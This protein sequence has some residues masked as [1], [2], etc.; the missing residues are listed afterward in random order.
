LDEASVAV[1]AVVT[2]RSRSQ[3]VEASLSKPSSVLFLQALPVFL[4][5]KNRWIKQAEPAKID[6][7]EAGFDYAQPPSLR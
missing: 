6:A 3:F 7:T 1:V 4:A 2:E 5:E